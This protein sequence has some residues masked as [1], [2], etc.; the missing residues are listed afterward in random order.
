MLNH[1]I[2]NCLWGPHSVDR[3][4][5]PDNAQLDQFNSRFWSM[6]SEA[7]DAF[8]CSWADENNWWCPA[9]HLVPRVI[10]HTQATQCRGTQ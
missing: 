10:R 2:F 4:A 1:A 9:I 8:T 5:N 7:V 3:F 6:G